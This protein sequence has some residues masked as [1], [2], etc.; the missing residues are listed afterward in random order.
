M[1]RSGFTLVELMI[2]VAII[3]LIASLSI[4]AL[5]RARISA[6]E[7]SAIEALRVISEAQVVF[8]VQGMRRDASGAHLYGTLSDL[9]TALPPFI[10]EVLESGSKSGYSFQVVLDDAPLSPR[11]EALATP[12]DFARTG[13]RHFFIN[14]EGVIRFTVDGTPADETSTPIG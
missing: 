4:P 9:G 10:D 8:I 11:Y 13:V 5:L 1:K 6:N 12:L 3:A 14:D 7:T 2:V